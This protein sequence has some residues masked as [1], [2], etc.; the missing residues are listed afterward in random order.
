M[1][2]QIFKNLKPIPVCKKDKIPPL[3]LDRDGFSKVFPVHKGYV[4]AMYR[5]DT[6]LAAAICPKCKTG[7][8][9][10]G[11]DQLIAYKH[12]LDTWAKDNS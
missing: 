4:Q 8:L 6:P 5:S 12:A 7:N 11:P 2:A 9:S 1:M 3:I 10:H